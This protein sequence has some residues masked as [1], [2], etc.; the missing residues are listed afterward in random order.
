LGVI[1]EILFELEQKVCYDIYFLMDI[2]VDWVADGLRDLGDQREKMLSIFK[3]EL[4]KRRIPY[5]LV[6]GTHAERETFVR[7]IIDQLLR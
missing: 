7:G 6:R 5:I 2:D 3:E 4:T 1:P